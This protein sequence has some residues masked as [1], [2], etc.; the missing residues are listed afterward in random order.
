MRKPWSPWAKERQGNGHGTRALR[1]AQPSPREAAGPRESSHRCECHHRGEGQPLRPKVG[2]QGVSSW[3]VSGNTRWEG[4]QEEGVSCL[5]QGRGIVFYECLSPD[6]LD[7]P[8]WSHLPEALPC[9]VQSVAASHWGHLHLNLTKFQ[10][11]AT[12][13]TFQALHSHTWLV[14]APL[15]RT[16]RN[17]SSQKGS[18]DRS[19]LKDALLF[20]CLCTPRPPGPASPCSLCARLTPPDPCLECPHVRSTPCHLEV[21]LSQCSMCCP[22]HVWH[23]C[24]YGAERLVIEGHFLQR[25]RLCYF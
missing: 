1:V 18:R 13:V 10:S 3:P 12:L 24:S 2:R 21:L 14:A 11:S 20:R 8:P 17:I 16:E 9:P 19:A 15:H 6:L 23:L 25:P 4:P 22:P 5:L 7:I